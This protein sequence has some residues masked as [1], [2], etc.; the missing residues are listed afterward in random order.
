MGSTDRPRV[1]PEPRVRR[2]HSEPRWAWLREALWLAGAAAIVTVVFAFTS[3]DTEAARVFYRPDSV[4][5][6]PFAEHPPWSLLYGAAPWMT[7]SLVLAGLL[8][9]V[10]GQLRHRSTWRRPAVF[11]LLSVAVGPG[12]LINTVFKDHWDRPRPREIVAFGGPLDYVAAPLSGD[13]IRRLLPLRS[14]FG[15]VSVRCGLVDLEAPPRFLGTTF[16]CGGNMRGARARSWADGG[17]SPLSVGCHMVGAAG[18]RRLSHPLLSRAAAPS[19]CHLASVRAA[20]ATDA[21]HVVWRGSACRRIRRCRRAHC[22]VRDSARH[23]AQH[24]YAL[25]V[26]I[27]RPKGICL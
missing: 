1:H 12:L 2:P 23:P 16:A 8:A 18:I 15:W 21:G 25:V 3:L 14:L 13:R 5:P 27:A 17:R 11:L 22:T 24:G 4:V 7:A 9:L 26:A 19:R 6:W 10:A 20:K